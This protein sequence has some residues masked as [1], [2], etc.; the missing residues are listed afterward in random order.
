[1][2]PEKRQNE[3]L[4]I[5]RAMQ[6]EF[7][8]EELTRMLGVS[9]LTVRR[10]LQKLSDVKAIIRTHGGCLAA[11]RVSLETEYYKKVAL[12]FELKQA[13]GRT[14]AQQVSS[15]EI[16]LINDG[17][18]TY[19]LAA[20][21]GGLGAL[22]VYTNSIA[23][24]SELSRHKNIRQYIL[25]GEYNPELHSLSGS[26]AEHMLELVHFDRVFLGVDAIDDEGRCMVGTLAEARLTQ[27]MLRSGTMKI[28]LAD[29]TKCGAVSHVAYGTLQDFDLWIT[30]PGM[31]DEEREKYREKTQI[32]EAA[33]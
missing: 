16:I 3:I 11:G 6:R 27:L 15:G 4:S 12:N 20:H 1:M 2:K 9:S 18:T 25:G 24:I 13:I 30:T 14:A 8:V 33:V 7:R 23:M 26:L 32:M 31:K 17:S 28:L 5:L 21:L 10:D 19:H 22:T 29:H